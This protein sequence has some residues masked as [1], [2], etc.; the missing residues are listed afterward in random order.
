M[1][2][3][4]KMREQSHMAAKEAEAEA[5]RATKAAKKDRRSAF[6]GKTFSGLNSQEKDDLLMALAIE[7]GIIEE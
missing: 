5:K 2:N 6:E 4:V 3:A 7:A 1:A